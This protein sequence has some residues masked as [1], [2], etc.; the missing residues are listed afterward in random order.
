MNTENLVHLSESEICE[1]IDVCGKLQQ[2]CFET[3]K[4][5]VARHN[6]YQR[7][8]LKLKTGFDLKD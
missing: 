7:L 3:Y 4:L 8:L 2:E 6:Y 5:L 1:A